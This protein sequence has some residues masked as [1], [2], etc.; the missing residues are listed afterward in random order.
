LELAPARLLEVA[1]EA[2]SRVSAAERARYP[3]VAWSEIVGLHNR[4]IH[5]YDAIDL[6]IL[7]QIVA[8]DLPP[9]VTA[10]EAILAGHDAP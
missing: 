4:L 5:G 10:P 9:L 6:D 3:L 7:W 2:A 8:Q 1:G